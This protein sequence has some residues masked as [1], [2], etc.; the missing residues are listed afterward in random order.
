MPLFLSLA[1]GGEIVSEEQKAMLD[2]IG[3][4][5]A[6]LDPVDQGK[7]SGFALGLAANK[8]TKEE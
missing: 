6:E 3:S 7:A 8:N 1:K 2:E 4:V 5:F